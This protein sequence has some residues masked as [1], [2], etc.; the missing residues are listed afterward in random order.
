MALKVKVNKRVLTVAAI[1]ALVIIAL[2][3]SRGRDGGDGPGT[4]DSPAAQACS[5]FNAGYAKAKSESSRLALADKVSASTMKTDNDA[6]SNA[7]MKVGDAANESNAEWKSAGDAMLKACR[8]A[9]W[10]S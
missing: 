3:V 1:A 5:D 6:I 7:A 4:L 2:V 9:G 10:S 8:D